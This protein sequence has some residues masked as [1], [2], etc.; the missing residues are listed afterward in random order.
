MSFY[1]E[2]AGPIFYP[3]VAREHTHKE[4]GKW[5][6]HSQRETTRGG[7]GGKADGAMTTVLGEIGGEKG[8]VMVDAIGLIC[9]LMAHLK[10]GGGMETKS[11]VAPVNSKGKMRLL[12][13][14]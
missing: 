3:G 4:P 10:T 8:M 6:H 7:S 12:A 9:L 13:T 11:R 2:I 1:T 14:T 5:T